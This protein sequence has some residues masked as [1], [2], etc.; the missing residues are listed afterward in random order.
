VYYLYVVFDIGAGD[1]R[2]LTCCA[3]KTGAQCTGVEIN[4]ERVEEAVQ[5]GVI[6]IN[7]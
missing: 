3:K 2:F 1:G 5:V 7:C 4:N 6:G